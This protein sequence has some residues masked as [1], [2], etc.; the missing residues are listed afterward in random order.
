MFFWKMVLN[1][2][3]LCNISVCHIDIVIYFFK[4]VVKSPSHNS[5]KGCVSK[6]HSPF[7]LRWKFHGSFVV[8]AMAC[9]TKRNEIAW[10][11][12]A[13][14]SAFNVMD[15]QCI[16]FRLSFTALTC[17]TISPKNVFSYIIKSKLVALL[18]SNSANIWILDLLNIETCNFNNNLAYR[19][20]LI[21]ILY[22]SKMTVD[23]TF[24]R[25]RKP[26]FMF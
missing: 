17:V 7:N 20:Y 21:N 24:D 26:P 9:P 6:R 15:F 22:N 4:P 14:L 19:K 3:M 23:F 12:T 5:H 2:V 1:P 25:R 13:S 11:V 18:V 16:V 10:R 8:S